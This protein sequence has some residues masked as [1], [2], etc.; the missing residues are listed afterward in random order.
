MRHR[1]W[2]MGLP[3][4]ASFGPFLAVGAVGQ[5]LILHWRSREK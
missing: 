5:R 4:R 1:D 3:V 2:L